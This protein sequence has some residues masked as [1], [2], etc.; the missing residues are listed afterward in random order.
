MLF[1]IL[2]M[3]AGAN[4]YRSIHSFIDVHLAFIDVHLERLRTHFGLSWRRAPA[5]TTIRLILQGLDG[6]AVGPTF[7]QH[8]SSVSV[9]LS[10]TIMAVYQS[11]QKPFKR[12]WKSRRR[13]RRDNSPAGGAQIIHFDFSS[14]A[15]SWPIRLPH[16]RP[17]EHPDRRTPTLA[18]GW[19]CSVIDRP[20]W[21]PERNQQIVKQ[22]ELLLRMCVDG[23][24]ISWLDYLGESKQ[25]ID[26]GLPLMEQAG[27]Q[28]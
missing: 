7:L 24:L 1:S 2:E 16:Y 11:R 17:Q 23:L 6:G 3:M 14:G 15:S 25:W 13:Q 4:S 18:L 5:Y 26:H 8:T 22:V 28:G 21:P 12:R 19:N 10:T 20:D 9:L 27:Y